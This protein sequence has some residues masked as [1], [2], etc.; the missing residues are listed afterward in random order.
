ML[1]CGGGTYSGDGQIRVEQFLDSLGQRG[2][3]RPGIPSNKI[4]GEAPGLPAARGRLD[5]RMFHPLR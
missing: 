1:A 3:D 2:F 5:P 4:R